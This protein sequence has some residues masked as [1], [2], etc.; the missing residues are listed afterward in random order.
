MGVITKVAGKGATYV[1]KKVAKRAAV[2]S[3]VK[4]GVVFKAA[5]GTALALGGVADAVDKRLIA[6]QTKK[7]QTD[8]LLKIY[9]DDKGCY[10]LE[11]IN[12]NDI[13][14]EL[15]RK[16]N[17]YITKVNTLSKNA[18]PY[19]LKI[20]KCKT[21][22]LKSA[23]KFSEVLFKV[24]GLPDVLKIK[25]KYH[26]NVM[27]TSVF[28]DF[29]N[30]ANDAFIDDNLFNLVTLHGFD[31]SL[32]EKVE[33]K[34]CIHESE[35]HLP[36]CKLDN[37]DD[38]KLV[39]NHFKNIIGTYEKIIKFANEYIEKLDVCNKRFNKKLK[40]LSAKQ[41]TINNYKKLKRLVNSLYYSM[42]LIFEIINIDLLFDCRINETLLMRMR[43]KIIK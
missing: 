43:R 40:K 30:K 3:F 9:K 31:L 21:N 19:L 7:S 11:T 38:L 29:I 39:T 26:I 12:K 1:G 27:P 35:I 24:E 2:R 6:K 25:N 33:T 17:P 23:Y 32:L 41:K 20:Y 8:T 15:T 16:V 18:K 14:D 36:M 42:H 13:S 22:F 37:E 34:N 5:A 28:K 4:G 10:D